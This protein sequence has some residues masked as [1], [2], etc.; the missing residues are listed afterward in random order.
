MVNTPSLAPSSP[1]TCEK[2]I[3]PPP[4]AATGETNQQPAP[5]G[6]LS[7]FELLGEQQWAG[8]ANWIFGYRAP[9]TLAVSN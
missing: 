5:G 8:R 4:Y 6:F 2:R 1:G 7:L 9:S 3:D